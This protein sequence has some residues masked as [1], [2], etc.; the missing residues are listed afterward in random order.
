MAVEVMGRD[1]GWIAIEAAARELAEVLLPRDPDW[2]LAP[3][4]AAR[5][6]ADGR[7]VRPVAATLRYAPAD[8]NL[9]GDWVRP[10]IM[11]YG[12]HT[13]PATVPAPDLKPVLS[14][15]TTIVQLRTIPRGGAV[16]YNTTFVAKRPTRNASASRPR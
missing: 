4:V 16:S 13:L 8:A 7:S 15:R 10:G 6:A 14:L 5:G 12:Y 3:A 9:R 11:L 1:A 2:E